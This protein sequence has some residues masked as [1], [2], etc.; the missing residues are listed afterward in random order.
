[1]KVDWKNIVSVLVDSALT[2]PGSVRTVTPV[3][4]TFFDHLAEA[5]EKCGLSPEMALVLLKQSNIHD[6]GRPDEIKKEIRR[7]LWKHRN[8]RGLNRETMFLWGV[9]DRDR[10]DNNPVFSFGW[11]A[12]TASHIGERFADGDRGPVITVSLSEQPREV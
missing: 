4:D 7:R 3:P 2:N 10:E 11:G 1:M 5:Q 8:A 9:M 12:Y 6:P